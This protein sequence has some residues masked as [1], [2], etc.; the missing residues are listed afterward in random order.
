[1]YNIYFKKQTIKDK[2]E[3]LEKKE[4]LK[5]KINQ[6]NY[7]NYFKQNKVY[8]LYNI[9]HLGDNVFNLIFFFL[10]NNY[11][12]QHNIIIYYYANKEYILQLNDFIYSKNVKLCSNDNRPKHAIE[13]W[14]NNDLFNYTHINAVNLK[15]PN[16]VNFN[17]YYKEFF[18][19]VLQLL[20]FNYK[21]TKF[22][23]KDSN[24]INRYNVMLDKYKKF[25]I[26]IV[27]STPLSGQFNYNK[28]EWDNY[29]C[30][31]NNHFN[32]ITT[33][34]VN[35]NILCTFDDNLTIKDIASLSTKAKIIIAINSGVVPGLL[36]Y[37]TLTNVKKFYI[38]DVNNTY[39]YPNFEHKNNI[40]EI[41]I[42]DINKYLTK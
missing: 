42:N 23:Y 39:S 34:K 8:H 36:N 19:S 4:Q 33:T 30:N 21:I 11:I 3:Q 13:L 41:T 1:M 17:L 40:N 12:E 9:Y 2:K 16:K 5:K 18:N 29:I 22:Y 31:L 26:L 6:I 28:I 20:N 10:I 37:Y 38:F 25:D 24:L 32:I 15:K 27:N 35:E 14:I 7:I